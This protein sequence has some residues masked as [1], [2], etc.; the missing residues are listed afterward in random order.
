METR[1]ESHTHHS[2]PCERPANPQ[3]DADLINNTLQL[4]ELAKERGLL[5]DAARATTLRD[6][7]ERLVEPYRA[8]SE[9]LLGRIRFDSAVSAW[10]PSWL[11]QASAA[12]SG[13]P[14]IERLDGIL[15][16]SPAALLGDKMFPQI[17]DMLDE[18][19]VAGMDDDARRLALHLSGAL[20]TGGDQQTAMARRLSELLNASLSH[21]SQAM[22]VLKNALEAT[23]PPEPR[24]TSQNL[25]PAAVS[26]TPMA[27]PV[28]QPPVLRKSHRQFEA[29]EAQ[30]QAETAFQIGASIGGSALT[31]TKIQ[32]APLPPS[33]TA[34]TGT[35]RT[36]GSSSSQAGKVQGF[37]TPLPP[38]AASSSS[39]VRAASAASA[40]ASRLF[41]AL[42][43]LRP[44]LE[45]QLQD[46]GLVT[47]LSMVGGKEG[48]M[49]IDGPQDGRIFIKQRRIIAA[50]YGQK[51]DLDAL[52]EIDA[53]KKAGFGFYIQEL[54]LAGALNLEISKLAEVLKSFRDDK[55]TRMFR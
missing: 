27:P 4:C 39:S 37:P 49:K 54:S 29:L 30:M 46:M 50:V 41:P 9:E 23:R 34:A 20:R 14:A 31:E 36:A 43:N 42:K 55:N 8:C 51:T 3:H 2:D 21:D 24:S 35:L 19:S 44:M 25:A 16:Q 5:D 32:P 12:L 52:V 28:K 48:V 13:G 40:G 33:P 10:L 47:T 15:T 18:L 7:L 6:I 26:A 53:V 1:M 38:M 22:L 45:G 17:S 11:A